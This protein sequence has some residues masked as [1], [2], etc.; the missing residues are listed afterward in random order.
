MV[1]EIL[2]PVRE[3]RPGQRFWLDGRVLNV[4]NLQVRGDSSPDGRWHLMMVTDGMSTRGHWYEGHEKVRLF[5]TNDSRIMTPSS[6]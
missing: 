5:G 2:V 6:A 4:A 3:L 1:D